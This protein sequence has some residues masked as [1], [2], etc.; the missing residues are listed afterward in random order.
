MQRIFAPG[1]HGTLV[2]NDTQLTDALKKIH[3][4]DVALTP[5]FQAIGFVH[6][7]TDD[8][9]IYFLSNSSNEPAAVTASFRINT[10]TTGLHP[11][12][13]N[14]LDGTMTPLPYNFS[15]NDGTTSIR[16]QLDPYGSKLIVW[17]KAPQ[18]LS[19]PLVGASPIDLSTDWN[20]TFASTPGGEGK[21]VHMD[22]LTS[23]TNLPT[24]KNYSGVATYEKKFTATADMLTQPLALSFGP[25]HPIPAG[26]KAVGGNG[27]S[28]QLTPPV[29]DVAVISLNGQRIGSVWCPP[30]TL[31]ISQLK[32][33]ENTLTIQVANTAVNY[34]AKAGFPNY[35]LEKIR[36]IYKNRF[37]PQGLNLYAQPL[38]SGLTGPIQLTPQPHP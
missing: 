36:A 15:F 37:D 12:S 23:W 30:Y 1:G 18:S 27:I 35:D 24:M 31:P 11:E 9:E 34:L 21:P 33:G 28:A 29:L 22:K 6:R 14:A 5:V 7:H 25:S 32:E 4:P 2:E 26:P 16:L 10:T 13:W 20:V 38:P 17:T 19:P 8:A 3:T